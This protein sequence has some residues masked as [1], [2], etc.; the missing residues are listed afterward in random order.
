MIKKTIDAAFAVLK[1]KSLA[2]RG[3]A[4]SAHRRSPRRRR[5]WPSTGARW[6]AAAWARSGA[7]WTA[8]SACRFVEVFEEILAA[9]YMDDI[10]RFQGTE[11]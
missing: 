10:D 8:S 2:G 5:P 11:T 4:P 7:A 9:R 1:D 3:E 6:R